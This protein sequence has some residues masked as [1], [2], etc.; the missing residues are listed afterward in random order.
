MRIG[1]LAYH[2]A[3]NFGA[4]LQLLSTYMF[5]KNNGYEPIVIN[6]VAS[7]LEAFYNSRSQEGQRSFSLN[8]RQNIWTES[9]LCRTSK[10][11]ANVISDYNI[12]GVIIGSDAVCQHHP[13]IERV[14]FPCRSIIKI[15]KYTTDRMFPNVFWGDFLN[16]LPHPVPVAVMSASSQDSAFNYFGPSLKK[17]MN[18]YIYRYSYLSVRDVWTQ[19][20]FSHISNGTIIPPVTPDPVFAFNYNAG[21]LVPNRED[22][23]KKFHLPEKYLLV[24]FFDSYKVS[25][26]WMDEFVELA[27]NK[28][29][30]CVSLPFAQIR[31]AIKC[32]YE[33]SL[34][35]SP[36]DWYALIKY[37]SG[38]IGNNMHPIVVSL[39]NQISF[40]SFDNYGIKKCRNIFTNVRSSKIKHI[41]DSAGMGDY[42]ISA[43]SKNFSQP[44]PLHVLN[45]LLSF[46]KKK[47]KI[48]ADSYYQKY[49]HMMQEII[50]KF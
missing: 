29:L 25:Q 41:L 19:K 12:G 43:I 45:K 3:I 16:Y 15:Q 47:S 10:E 37:S 24:S 11:V 26:S 20:M 31:S 46:D 13:T 5:F 6:W 27:S 35:L 39:H 33:I 7:D 30:V 22:I 32:P 4:T 21:C 8:L 34:P 49:Q 18:K 9:R 48:F 38:Y 14:S 28:D 23:L 36:I 17:K 1:L 42:R 50:S 2:S 40:F 44:A